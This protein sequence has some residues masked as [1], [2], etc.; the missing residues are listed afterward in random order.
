MKH[1]SQPPALIVGLDP[2][3]APPKTVRIAADRQVGSGVAR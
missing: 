2:S 1:T 3:A